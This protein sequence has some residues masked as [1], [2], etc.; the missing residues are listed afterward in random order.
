M[1]RRKPLTKLQQ[2]TAK[3]YKKAADSGFNDIETQDGDLKRPGL[4]N[5]KYYTTIGWEAKVSYYTMAEFFLNDYKFE[6]TMDK[7]MWE[8]HSHGLSYREIAKLLKH[9]KLINKISYV[10]V[11][12]KVNKMRNSMY[13]MYVFPEEEASE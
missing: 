6:T 4:N 1:A 5:H 8:Y 2:L 13:A 11:C 3:W 12:H 7:V 9:L 10:T